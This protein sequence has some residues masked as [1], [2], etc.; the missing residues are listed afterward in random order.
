MKKTNQEL[1]NLYFQSRASDAEVA[2]L[3]KRMLA[4]SDLRELYLQ[5]A[6]LETNLNSIALREDDL[7]TKPEAKPERISSKILPFYAAAAAVIAL[8][9]MI[10]FYN[11]PG[12]SV[13]TILS[14]ELAGWQSDQPTIEGG[15][16]GPG[17]FMPVS[18]THLRAHET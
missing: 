16:F 7:T 17:T 9:S 15:E 18:Y 2:E 3:E 6:I 11:S 13:G 1:L 5:E 14:S 4:D 10:G 12:K 8:I